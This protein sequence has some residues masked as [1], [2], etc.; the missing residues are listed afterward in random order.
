MFE[1]HDFR[2]NVFDIVDRIFTTSH[3]GS[4]VIIVVSAFDSCNADINDRVEGGY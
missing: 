2:V 3:F 1:G 4:S